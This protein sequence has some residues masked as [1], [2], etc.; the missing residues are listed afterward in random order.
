MESSWTSDDGK[1]WRRVVVGGGF[2]WLG[3]YPTEDNSRPDRVGYLPYFCVS[4]DPRGRK[5]I[6]GVFESAHLARRV[7]DEWW[8]D[9]I[10]DLNIGQNAVRDYIDRVLKI[11]P[12]TEALELR[13]KW[14]REEQAAA[15]KS[16]ADAIT[17]KDQDDK[18]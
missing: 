14:A 16:L 12:E 17:I 11:G 9:R 7:A 10:A 15:S 6:S 1:V 4:D 3:V 8:R 2:A 5:M 13:I 18:P